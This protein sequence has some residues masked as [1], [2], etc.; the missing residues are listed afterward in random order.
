MIE[1]IHPMYGIMPIIINLARPYIP[2]I[3]SALADIEET[4]QYLRNYT[5]NKWVQ[6]IKANYR[7]NKRARRRCKKKGY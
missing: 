1:R 7:K 3:E 4:R 6:E 5:R 2:A